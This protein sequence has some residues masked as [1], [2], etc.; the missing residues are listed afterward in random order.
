MRT[1]AIAL[2]LLT[3]AWQNANPLLHPESA[4]FTRPAP[5]ASR[6]TLA[7]TQGDVVIEITRRWAPLGADRFYN[8]ARL[9]YYDDMRIHRVSGTKWAQFG[10]NGTPAV[11]KA[12]RTATFPDDPFVPEHSNVRGTI[13]FAYKDRNARTTQVFINLQDNAA[14]HDTEPFVPFGRVIAG[15]DVVDRWNKEYGE[16]SGGG[17]RAGKQDPLFEGGNAYFDT[18]WPRLDRIRAV[19]VK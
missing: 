6:V 17:I 19:T 11:A 16:D 14:T 5:A 15:M 4:E 7:T 13:A 12:W 3:L 1:T 2:A 18:M 8:L 9:G 10:I